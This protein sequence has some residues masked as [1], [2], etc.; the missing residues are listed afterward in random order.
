MGSSSSSYTGGDQDDREP[1][2]GDLIEIFRDNYEHWAV[3]VGA[4]FVVHF[5]NHSGVS[6]GTSVHTANGTVRKEKIWDVVGK[7]DWKINNSMDSQYEPRPANAIVKDAKA[8]VG[9]ELRYNLVSFNCEH[10][11]KE[12]RYGVAE[13]LQVEK[14]ALGVVGG[15]GVI[16]LAV[17]G[18]VASRNGL[19]SF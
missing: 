10:F 11:V 19:S 13:S 1:E 18:S 8:M 16:A 17:R 12:L 2:L 3:Y 15:A 5:V 4:G 6:S 7:D 9:K 14:A